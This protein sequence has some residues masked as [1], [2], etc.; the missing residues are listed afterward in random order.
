MLKWRLS[1][2]VLAGALAL[3]LV[4]S[5]GKTF[6]GSGQTVVQAAS[7]PEPAYRWTFEDTAGTAVAN[8]GTVSDAAATLK[9][10]AK[11]QQE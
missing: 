6:P 5:A 7:V 1:K 11:I 4:V 8:S 10:T 9:G 2:R 3:T